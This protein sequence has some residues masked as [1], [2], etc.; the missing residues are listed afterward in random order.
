MS[1]TYTGL[2]TDYTWWVNYQG[3]F[4]AYDTG[5]HYRDA[6]VSYFR[7]LDDIS[8]YTLDGRIFESDEGP[9]VSEFSQITAFVFGTFMLSIITISYFVKSNEKK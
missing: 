9:L 3:E 2:M 4:S 5:V 6:V 8:L 7:T 1:K